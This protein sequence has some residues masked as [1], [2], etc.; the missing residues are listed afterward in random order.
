MDLLLH[1]CCAICLAGPLQKLQEKGTNIVG[2]FYN[3]NIHPFLEFRKRI[4]AL[5]V[6]QEREHIK[7]DYFLDYGLKEYLERVDYKDKNN[8]CASCYRLR[9]ESTAQ[10]G[11]IRNF[12]A[13]STTLLFSQQQ[14]HKKIKSLGYEI[15]D[16]VGIRFE[17]LDYRHL[18]M[19]SH[20]IAKRY[21]LYRQSYCGCIFSEYERYKDTTL[22]LYKKDR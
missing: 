10:L 13:F 8:R 18:S 21:M 17:Y 5:K 20:E 4:K 12:D 14:D 1:V 3:P 7:I 16:K 15:S 6:L 2:Y 19:V 9:L 22:H 11:K